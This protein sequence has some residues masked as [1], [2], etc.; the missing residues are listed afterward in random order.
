MA[1][2]PDGKT[3]VVSHF[4]KDMTVWDV[5][6]RRL[7]NSLKETSDN[8]KRPFFTPDSRTLVVC[9]SDEYA[10]FLDLASGEPTFVLEAEKGIDHLA[11]SGHGAL[12]ATAHNKTVALWDVSTNPWRD[13]PIPNHPDRREVPSRNGQYLSI[14]EMDGSISLWSFEIGERRRSIKASMF[15]WPATLGMVTSSDGQRLAFARQ[16]TST[17]PYQQWEEVILWD[18][19]AGGETA[20][21]RLPWDS[22]NSVMDFSPDSR[23]LAT[24]EAD[25]GV[26]LWDVTNGSLKAA[27]RRHTSPVKLL[28]FSADCK[29]LVSVSGGGGKKELLLWNTIT[30]KRLPPINSPADDEVVCV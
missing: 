10:T 19:A 2:S 26:R 11:L 25:G 12:C 23:T 3:V 4:K 15:P 9:D 13:A 28:A 30:G 22:C 21:L 7:R 17:D 18:W 8:Q 27:L 1:L 16:V 14:R 20:R 24:G 29:T 6:T 5:Q